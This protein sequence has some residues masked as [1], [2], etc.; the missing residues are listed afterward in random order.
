MRS[1]R[2]KS[3]TAQAGIETTG[4]IPHSVNAQK[5]TNMLSIRKSP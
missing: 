2:A 3:S 1:P 4:S 5:L